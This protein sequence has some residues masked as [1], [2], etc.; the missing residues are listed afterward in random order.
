MTT[1]MAA[2]LIVGPKTVRIIT[3]DVWFW[4]DCYLVREARTNNMN[5]WYVFKGFDEKTMEGINLLF[6]SNDI[7]SLKH[8]MDIFAEELPHELVE[9]LHP[10]NT[11]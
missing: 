1:P 8:L 11:N 4:K 7:K 5:R 6:Y 2:P 9:A 3:K 10:S